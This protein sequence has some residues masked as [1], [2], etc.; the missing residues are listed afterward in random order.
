MTIN[1]KKDIKAGKEVFG[2]L[3]PSEVEEFSRISKAMGHPVRIKLLQMFIEQGDWVCGKLV[4][5][6]DLA[7]STVSEHL[8]I[9]LEAKLIKREIY[10]GKGRKYC[11]NNETLKKYKILSAKL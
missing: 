7:Q 10:P 1:I 6:F 4:D 2:N 3:I 11:I 5:H 9:L 8:R